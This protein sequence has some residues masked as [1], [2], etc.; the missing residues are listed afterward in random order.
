MKCPKAASRHKVRIDIATSTKCNLIP[1]LEA[2]ACVQPARDR[3][4]R[5][6]DVRVREGE[7]ERAECSKVINNCPLYR[8]REGKGKGVQPN[9]HLQRRSLLSLIIRIVFCSL[10]FE[11]TKIDKCFS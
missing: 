8:G 4:V 1:S 10:N 11:L 2:C 7:G 9:L 3:Q 5:H 6:I